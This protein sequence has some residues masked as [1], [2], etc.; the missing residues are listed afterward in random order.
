MDPTR[1]SASMALPQRA[2]QSTVG[3]LFRDRARMHPERPAVETAVRTLTYG[4]LND[5]VNRAVEV[6][7][8]LGVRRGDRVA[9]LSENRPEYLA[10]AL[11]CA[12]L[13]SRSAWSTRMIV[14]SRSACRGSWLS[15]GSRSSAA[16]G[17]LRRRTHAT[18]VAAGST[19]EIRHGRSTPAQHH[20][21]DPAPRGRSLV[22][23]VRCAEFKDEDGAA[24][25]FRPA[26]LHGPAFRN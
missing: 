16:T 14:T 9:I 5:R 8:G 12:K 6:L 23:S 10:L 25:T 7:H 24:L 13:G 26:R 4:E 15:G 17:T 3:S 20:G 19:W 21:Q 18:S 1:S 22:E 2:G 11:A